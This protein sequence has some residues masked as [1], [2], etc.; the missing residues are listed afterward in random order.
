VSTPGFAIFIII[1]VLII[2]IISAHSFLKTTAL[3]KYSVGGSLGMIIVLC[4]LALAWSGLATII[5]GFFYFWGAIS[6]VIIGFHNGGKIRN[7]IIVGIRAVFGIIIGITVTT[8]IPKALG[9]ILELGIIVILSWLAFIEIMSISRF[10]FNETFIKV[11]AIG[12]AISLVVF[13]PQSS[14][15]LL[16]VESKATNIHAQANPL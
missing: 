11:A 12:G 13:D 14:V 6:G 2:L 10:D 5:I 1:L 9:I 8:F 7:N 3:A 16:N 15:V 4:C